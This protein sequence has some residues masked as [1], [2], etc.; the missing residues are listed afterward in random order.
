METPCDQGILAVRPTGL[1]IGDE[2]SARREA[3]RGRLCRS[4]PDDTVEV[5][6]QIDVAIA[7]AE[8][9]DI[10][11]TPDLV[12]RLVSEHLRARVVSRSTVRRTPPAVPLV[13]RAGDAG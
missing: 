12:E 9:L 1:T 2:G 10:P 11:V 3:V 4:F 6:R 8:H 7:C 13:C 5:A